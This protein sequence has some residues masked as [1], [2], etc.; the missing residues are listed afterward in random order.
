[1]IPFNSTIPDDPINIKRHLNFATSIQILFYITFSVVKI[2][3]KAKQAGSTILK[4]DDEAL[5][6]IRNLVL[7]IFAIVLIFIIV[8][9]NFRAD[10]G[11]YFIGTYVSIFTILT[12]FR[13][14]NDSAYFDRPVSFMDITV[15]K[16]TKSSLTDERKEN[17]LKKILREFEEN[18]YFSDNL[19]SLSDLSKKIG[20][21][22]HHVSQVINEKMGKS[23]FELLA[24]FRIEKATKILAGDRND[25]LTIE[26]LSEMVGYNSK[27]AFN[28]AFKKITGKTPSEFRNR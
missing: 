2:N 23:F 16:Y 12:T 27:T 5:K 20:E 21:G 24:S 1:M 14:M 3:G 8:K 6:S 19:A 13:V 11:D 4:T 18:E 26:E 17:I 7:H 15:A 28:N 25:K 10:L 9:L 22:Q